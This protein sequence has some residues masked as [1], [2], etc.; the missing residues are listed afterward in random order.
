LAGAPRRLGVPAKPASFLKAFLTDVKCKL[1]Y[2]GEFALIKPVI[3]VK[4][5][6][7]LGSVLVSYHMAAGMAAWRAGFKGTA[8]TFCTEFDDVLSGRAT[9]EP[10]RTNLDA[11]PVRP[12]PTVRPQ[13]PEHRRAAVR[14]PPRALLKHA[15]DRTYHPSTALPDNDPAFTRG[16]PMTSALIQGKPV[17]RSSGPGAP[18]IG[19]AT[20][21]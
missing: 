9:N 5:G 17:N 7:L 6:D 2:E 3:G 13:L 4:Q 16:A 1:D 14:A 12:A 8:P 19:P 10:E 20:W 21:A 15:T 18:P 11:T